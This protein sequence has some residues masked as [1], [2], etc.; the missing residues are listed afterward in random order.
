MSIL[1]D[2]RKLSAAEE[3]FDLLGVEYD[4]NIVRHSRLHILRRMGEYLHKAAPEGASD[5]E[6]RE[7][8]REF[9]A[10]AY[11]DFTKSSPI[12]ERLFKVHKDAVKPKEEPK[13]PF[14]PL[15]TVTTSNG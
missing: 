12:E 1:D 11:Q 15:S 5:D 2:L 14:V 13:K 10:K 7:A 9:L 6:V 8:C 4:P 3:F